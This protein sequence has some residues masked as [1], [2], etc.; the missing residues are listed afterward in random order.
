MQTYQKL[1]RGSEKD[2]LT[3]TILRSAASL[4]TNLTITQA[5]QLRDY[6]KLVAKWQTIMNL[7]AAVSPTRF[8]S[9]HIVDCLSVRPFINGRR[10]VDIGS[11]AGLPGLVL[12]IAI[13]NISVCLLESNGKRARFLTQAQFELELSNVEIINVRLQRYRPACPYDTII[14]RAFGSLPYLMANIGDLKQTDTRLIVMKGRIDQQ[15]ISCLASSSLKVEIVNLDV[16]GFDE[17][18]LVIIDFYG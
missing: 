6:A 16:P 5:N 11:G 8:V 3:E 18:N 7:T 15:E 13:P 9:D 1:P 10:L 2:S 4:R 14:A 17:R 12:A